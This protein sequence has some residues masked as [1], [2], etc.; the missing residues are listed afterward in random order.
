[1]EGLYVQTFLGLV[2]ESFYKSLVARV[3]HKLVTHLLDHLVRSNLMVRCLQALHVLN[4]LSE[5]GFERNRIDLKVLDEDVCIT[6]DDGFT[7]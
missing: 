4:Q 5:L 6:V 3:L 2:V 7:I 1:M